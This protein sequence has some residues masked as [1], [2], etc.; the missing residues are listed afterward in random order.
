MLQARRSLRQLQ[1]RAQALLRLLLLL[2]REER[3]RSGVSVQVKG[4]RE[5]GLVFRALH[6]RTR[7]LTIL[8]AC[9]DA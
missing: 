5:V 3:S 7:T 9:R 6:A 1:V 8:N 2:L 4:G